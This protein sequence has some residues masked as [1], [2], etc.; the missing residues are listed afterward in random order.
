[1][2]TKKL[3]KALVLASLAR[4]GLNGTLRVQRSSLHAAGRVL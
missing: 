4:F 2:Q 1:M 3:D